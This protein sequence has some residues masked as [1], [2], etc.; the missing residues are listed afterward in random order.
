M[1]DLF[2]LDHSC[3]IRDR[4]EGYQDT[5][6]R[7]DRE[8]LAGNVDK[9]HRATDYDVESK[10]LK[11]PRGENDQWNGRD[12]LLSGRTLQLVLLDLPELEGRSYDGKT[13]EQ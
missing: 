6:K 7:H 12:L 13:S 8:N 11:G 9:E 10:A 4:I 5:K 3:L 2:L 1:S